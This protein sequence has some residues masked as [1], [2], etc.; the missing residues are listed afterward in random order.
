M[1]YQF[2]PR[3]KIFALALKLEAGVIMTSFPQLLYLWFKKVEVHFL[4]SFVVLS[5][6]SLKNNRKII[7]KLPYLNED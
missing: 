7:V 2:Q 5:V 3:M 1:Q 4:W 6:S